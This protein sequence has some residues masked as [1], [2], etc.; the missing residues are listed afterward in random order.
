VAILYNVANLGASLPT[1]KQRCIHTSSHT[2]TRTCSHT[3]TKARTHI[4]TQM[5]TNTHAHTHTNTH[6]HTIPCACTH[7]HSRNKSTKVARQNTGVT[8][9][10]CKYT[11]SCVSSLSLC[12]ALARAFSLLS[13]SLSHSLSLSL[14]L[15]LCYP[16]SH[17]HTHTHS[18]IHTHIH[19][20]WVWGGST[21]DGPTKSDEVLFLTLYI[22]L[23]FTFFALTFPCS[24][25]DGANMYMGQKWDGGNWLVPVLAD[26]V[27]MQ[28]TEQERNSCPCLCLVPVHWFCP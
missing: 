19:T 1:H 10:R 22:W 8:R 24:I 21:W 4:R 14:S 7:T 2:H 5:H 6:T 11:I 15:S 25:A 27:T 20:L 23:A 28:T 13:F 17:A 3:Q 16:L 26:G 18:H 9:H 12:F